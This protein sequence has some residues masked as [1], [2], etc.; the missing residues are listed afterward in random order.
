MYDNTKE[1]TTEPSEESDLSRNIDHYTC[2][3]LSLLC[4]SHSET[5]SQMGAMYSG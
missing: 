1:V 4:Q 3:G 5:Q 2:I